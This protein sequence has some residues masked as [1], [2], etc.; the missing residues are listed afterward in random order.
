MKWIVAAIVAAAL[1]FAVAQTAPA[2]HASVE[3]RNSCCT[4]FSPAP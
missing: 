2:H 1:G 3:V 4:G